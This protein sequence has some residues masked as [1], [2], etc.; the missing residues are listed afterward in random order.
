MQIRYEHWRQLNPSIL[1][2]YEKCVPANEMERMNQPNAISH[3]ISAWY[4]A[5]GSATITYNNSPLQISAG[6]WVFPPLGRRSQ[7][8]TGPLQI[9]SITIAANWPDGRPLFSNNL[10]VTCSESKLNLLKTAKS[11][12]S[13][14]QAIHPWSS[15]YLGI[16]HINLSQASKLASI[17][18]QWTDALAS[19]LETLGIQHSPY[20]ATNLTIKNLQKLLTEAPLNQ[21]LKIEEACEILSISR[22]Q[23][24]RLLN[25]HFQ[26]TF[27]ELSELRRIKNAPQIL[28]QTQSIKQTANQLGFAHLPNFNRWF[29]RHFGQ[30]PKQHLKIHG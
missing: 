15:W 11:T 4:I 21:K 16:D 10:P 9:F 20:L 8:F 3:E 23:L 26:T 1:W 25:Q 7:I 2:A 12:I 17:S 19:K 24:N 5:K 29:Q 27:T 14:I 13:Q 6:N 28:L 22:S 18:G 30:N